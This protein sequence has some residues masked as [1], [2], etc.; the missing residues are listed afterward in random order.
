MDSFIAGSKGA[1]VTIGNYEENESSL[2][3]EKRS[4]LD[5][6]ASYVSVLKVPLYIASLLENLFK[7]ATFF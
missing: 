4:L 3:K 6:V 1:V 7:D 2:V 5:F